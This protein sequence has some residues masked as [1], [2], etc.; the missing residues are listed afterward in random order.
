M[1]TFRLRVKIGPH[2]FEAE[3]PKDS[4]MAQFEAWKTLIGSTPATTPPVSKVVAPATEVPTRE[5]LSAPW[6]VF[7]VDEKRR[8]VTLR[9][10]PTG[11]TRD[12]DAV[13]GQ[14]VLDRNYG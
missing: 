11:E 8:L 2:E 9:V 3:G 1:E 10:H 4:V 6:D 13:G 14:A 5:G 7:E 12:A